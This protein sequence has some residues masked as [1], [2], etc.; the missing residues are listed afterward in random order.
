MPRTSQWQS[1][2]E[3]YMDP[4][5]EAMQE[6]YMQ[7][8]MDSLISQWSAYSYEDLPSD[9][10][11]IMFA[12]QYFDPNSNLTLGEQIAN[13]LNNVLGATVPTDAPNWEIMPEY[14]SKNPPNRTNH[15]TNPVYTGEEGEKIRLYLQWFRLFQ[16]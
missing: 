12:L 2:Q 10:F 15:T 1:K 3:A 5:S 4:G 9:K 6:G 14:E 11:G 8:R 7:E 16:R 13:F